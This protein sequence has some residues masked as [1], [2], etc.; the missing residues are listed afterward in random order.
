VRPSA[1]PGQ[2]V[3][4]V[5]IDGSPLD[6]AKMYTVAVTD[7]QSEG[8]D[9]YG[10]FTTQKV[11]LSPETGPLIVNALEKYIAARRTVSPAKEGRIRIE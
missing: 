8:G 5:T 10:V 9:G 3:S 6:P 2:R 1:P 7:Y 4:S 11:L